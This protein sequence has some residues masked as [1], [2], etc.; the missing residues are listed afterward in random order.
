MIGAAISDFEP[1]VA[2][3]VGCDGGRW[4]EFLHQRGWTVVGSDVNRASLELC[5]RRLPTGTFIECL[6]ADR[7]LPAEDAQ[8]QLLLVLE[9]ADVAQA[10]WFPAEAARVL[11]PGGRLVFA[12]QN[13]HS[14]RGLAYGALRRLGERRTHRNFYADSYAAFTARLLANGLRMISAEGF[15]WLPFQRQSDSRLIPVATGFEKVVGLRRVPRFSPFV[16]GLAVRSES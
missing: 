1:G 6:P 2:F 15:A 8:A 7:T 3:E 11:A 5:R 4:C 9:V 14:L 16:A 13:G 12:I 10:E